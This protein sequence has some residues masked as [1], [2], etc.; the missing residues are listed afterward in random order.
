VKFWLFYKL[1]FFSQWKHSWRFLSWTFLLPNLKMFKIKS[2]FI[3]TLL[4]KYSNGEQ[5]LLHKNA[6]F[7]F[8]SQM[9]V[10]LSFFLHKT[11]KK[12]QKLQHFFIP[13]INQKQPFSINLLIKLMHN[14]DL[15]EAVRE[16]ERKLARNPRECSMLMMT[17]QRITHFKIWAWYS[18]LSQ[19]NPSFPG[20][21]DGYK[22]IFTSV[23]DGFLTT[24]WV[25]F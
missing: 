2:L 19:A 8:S 14:F 6:N 16:T 18:L 10:A 24:V 25:C 12:W 9:L 3:H 1:G 5:L 11:Y 21:K 15:D 17:L 13:K 23:F 22:N 7:N 20:N 4:V